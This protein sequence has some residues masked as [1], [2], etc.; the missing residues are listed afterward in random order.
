M[1]DGRESQRLMRG[2]ADPQKENNG[3][4]FSLQRI[5]YTSSGGIENHGR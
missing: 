5:I 3:F 1:L 2:M 4:G